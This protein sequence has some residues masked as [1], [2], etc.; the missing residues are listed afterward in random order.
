[1]SVPIQFGKKFGTT[2]VEG[3]DRVTR[4]QEK[5]QSCRE[6]LTEGSGEPFKP[7]QQEMCELPTHSSSGLLQITCLPMILCNRSHSKSPFDP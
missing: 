2:W 5:S 6:V 1:M 4:F 3:K 7:G